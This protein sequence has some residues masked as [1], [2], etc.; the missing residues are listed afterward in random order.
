MINIADLIDP[1]DSQGRTYREINLSTK[2]QFSLDDLVELNTGARLFIAKLTRDCDGTPL[3]SLSPDVEDGHVK[4]I[5]GYSEDNL[6]LV[7]KAD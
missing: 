3:Y 4:W 1:N 7:K 2:H 5:Y 6:K